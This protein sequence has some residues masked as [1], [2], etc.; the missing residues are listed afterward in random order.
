M[1]DRMLSDIGLS[2]AQAT[3]EA[4]RRFWDIE[5]APRE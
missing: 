3:H 1:D 5:P 2:R 4:S